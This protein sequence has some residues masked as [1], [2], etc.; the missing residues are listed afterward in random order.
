MANLIGPL[1]SPVIGAGSGSPAKRGGNDTMTDIGIWFAPDYDEDEIDSAAGED[2][3][4]SDYCSMGHDGQCGQAG[5]EHCDFVCPIMA[6]I[7]AKDH[8]RH[9]KSKRKRKG[10]AQ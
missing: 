9:E 4:D 6:E 10:P 7:R 5:S 8:A 1:S 3:D 2:F